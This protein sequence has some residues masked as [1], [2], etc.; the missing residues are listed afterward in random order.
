MSYQC[1]QLR[2]LGPEENNYKVGRDPRPSGARCG[3]R[4]TR[5]VLLVLVVLVSA[6]VRAETKRRDWKELDAQAERLFHQGKY[7]EA[8]AVAKQAVAAAEAAFGLDSPEV[9]RALD[10]LGEVYFA[11][12]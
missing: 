12:S 9:A 6:G 1:T 4:A 10:R 5:I 11:E 3:L 8:E 7:T 2:F